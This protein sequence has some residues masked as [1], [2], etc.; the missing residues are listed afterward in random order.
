MSPVRRALK[1]A[2]AAWITDAGAASYIVVGAVSTTSMAPES[3]S[4]SASVWVLE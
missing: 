4:E 2:G 3:V 1:V